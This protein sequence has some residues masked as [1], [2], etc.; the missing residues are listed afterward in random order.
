MNLS[1]R[2]KLAL[3]LSLSL[4]FWSIAFEGLKRAEERKKD[5]NDHDKD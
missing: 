1:D 4:M 5:G 3:A 2:D